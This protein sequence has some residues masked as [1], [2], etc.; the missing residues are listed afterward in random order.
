MVAPDQK[1]RSKAYFCSFCGHAHDQV[2]H[3]IPGPGNIYICSECVERCNAILA[4]S[5]D[6]RS[7]RV[8]KPRQRTAK[9]S[10]RNRTSPAAGPLNAVERVRETYEDIVYLSR[11]SLERINRH[12]HPAE[13]YCSTQEYIRE[14]WARANA[15]SSFAVR[16]GLISSEQALQIILDFQDEHPDA[17]REGPPNS[18]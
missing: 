6:R 3:L 7:G 9:V 17:P 8:R 14:L 2:P 16:T 10:P 1:D 4:Q 11:L 13:R 18:P 15:V 5:R 12:Q